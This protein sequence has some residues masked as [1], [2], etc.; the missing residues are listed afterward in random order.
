MDFGEP[1]LRH[2]RFG[3]KIVEMQLLK[4]DFYWGGYNTG[5]AIGDVENNA[6]DYPSNGQYGVYQQGNSLY[7]II[8]TG[9]TALNISV[10]YYESLV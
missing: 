7:S 1:D 10:L 2:V 4:E 9:A 6:F 8:D 3:S 5:V